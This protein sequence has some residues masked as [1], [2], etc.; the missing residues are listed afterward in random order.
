MLPSSPRIRS[1]DDAVRQLV[2]VPKTK[3]EKKIAADRPAK[4]RRKP[5]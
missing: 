2:H 1:F 4:S 3:V 5:A